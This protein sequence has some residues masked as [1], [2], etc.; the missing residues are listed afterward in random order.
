MSGLFPF[1]ARLPAAL[2]RGARKAARWLLYLLLVLAAVHLLATFITGRMLK[3]ELDRI[4]DS[5]EPLTHAELAPRVPHGEANAADI[6]QQ[7]FDSLRLSDTESLEVEDFNR[8]DDPAWL[9]LARRVVSANADYYSLLEQASQIPSCAFPVNWEARFAATFRHL[10]KMRQAA[11]MLRVRAEVLAADGDI[12]GAVASC[13]VAFRMAEHVG[14][15]PTL[16][17]VLVGIAIEGIQIPALER[18]LFAGAPS[19]EAA[20]KLFNELGALDET[21]PWARTMLGERAGGLWTFRYLRQR[22]W[23]ELTKD[24]GLVGDHLPWKAVSYRAYVSPIGRPL[25][26]SLIHI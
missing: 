8:V 18:V 14:M 24:D 3:A 25:L 22:S 19:P 17:A 10:A 26:L 5:G 16:I 1:F 9:A 6:Y 15:E 20:H 12:D 13:A 2:A 21:D 23:R 7:A 4:R 11:R